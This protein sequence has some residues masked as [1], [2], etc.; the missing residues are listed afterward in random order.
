[1]FLNLACF[2]RKVENIGQDEVQGLLKKIQSLELND[3]G[4]KSIQDLKKRKL[5]AE[6]NVT[7]LL[8]KKG[9][10]FTTSVEKPEKELTAEMMVK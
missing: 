9:K 10:N 2:L 4:E 6:L 1:M 3:V 5:I 8:V 7:Y